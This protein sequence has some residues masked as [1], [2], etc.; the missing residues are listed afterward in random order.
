ML[1]KPKTAKM[2]NMKTEKQQFLHNI[3]I[4][5]QT[6]KEKK[7]QQPNSPAYQRIHEGTGMIKNWERRGTVVFSARERKNSPLNWTC[8]LPKTV[9]VS[10]QGLCTH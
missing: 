6:N 3:S 7:K 8:S 4:K 2:K 5:K 10:L 1:A 9:G